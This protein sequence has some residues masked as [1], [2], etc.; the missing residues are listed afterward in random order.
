[1][2]NFNPRFALAMVAS[3]LLAACNKPVATEEPVR[4]VKV[5]ALGEAGSATMPEFSG[6]VRARVESRLGFRV[7]GKIVRRL[8]EVGQ[9]VRAGQELAQLD[10]QDYQLG[11]DNARA[12]LLAATTARDLASA[13]LRRFKDLREQNFISAAEIE[14]REANLK[15]AQAQL[16]QA[17]VQVQA[18]AHQL[19][20]A[21]LRAEAAGVVTALE[22]E[23]GQVVAA[24]TPIVRLAQDGARDVVFAL[25]EDQLQHIVPGMALEVRPWQGTASW[26]AVVREV[27][28][29]AD[30]VTRTF[31]VKLTLPS[32]AVSA[33]GSTMRVLAPTRAAAQPGAWR[34]PTSALFQQGSGSAVWVLDSSSMTVR[35]QPVEVRS[36]DGNDVVLGGSLPRGL[37]VVSTGVHVLNAGQ[38]VA[39]FKD[40]QAET[41][42]HQASSAMN[43]VAS[44][45]HA[46]SAQK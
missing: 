11:L 21:S 35:A 32:G 2:L 20:Y 28:A 31:A 3:L 40:K 34:L 7:G 13:D 37:L 1:M 30:P 6:E 27:A 42:V 19:G 36:L 24:G 46:A 23:V 26:Q 41:P 22:A 5:M 33:L 29:S 10:T 9:S 25:P 14:R 43:S 17:Q 39:I 38:K 45:Q 8:V 16:D 44:M 12:Q 4:S 15:A 18:Q